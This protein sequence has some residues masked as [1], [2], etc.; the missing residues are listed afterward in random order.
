MDK[1]VTSHR[2]LVRKEFFFRLAEL[3]NS[4]LAPEERTTYSWL[5]DWFME[6]VQVHMQRYIFACSGTCC[7]VTY[8]VCL[9]LCVF[10]IDFRQ[11]IKNRLAS[12]RTEK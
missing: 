3:A 7:G 6:T 12:Q 1:V 11:N 5:C 2:A 8:W 9:S 10:L 4:A